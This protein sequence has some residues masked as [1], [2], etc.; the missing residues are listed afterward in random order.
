M[1]DLFQSTGNSDWF[2]QEVAPGESVQG[3]AG[4]DAKTKLAAEIC[5]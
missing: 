5:R 2:R 4:C 3:V 1:S